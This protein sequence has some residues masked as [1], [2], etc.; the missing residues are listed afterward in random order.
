MP[1]KK[2]KK[3]VTNSTLVQALKN[4]MGSPSILKED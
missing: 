2:G 4:I 1:V 3:K